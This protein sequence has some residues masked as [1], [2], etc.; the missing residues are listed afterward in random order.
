MSR[1]CGDR[2]MPLPNK[3][4][5]PVIDFRPVFY[6]TGILLVILAAAMAVPA[7]ADAA[8]GDPDWLVFASSAAVTLFVG[9]ALVL[10]NRVRAAGGSIRQAFVLVTVSWIVM[11]AFA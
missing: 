4:G 8:S 9:V 1:I 11:A 10:T 3:D 2:S 5:P 6:A 7:I